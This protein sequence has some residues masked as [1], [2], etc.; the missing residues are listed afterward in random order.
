[1]AQGAI[2]AK[3]PS[4]STKSKKPAVLGPKKGSR[5]IAPKKAV[6]VKNAKITKVGYH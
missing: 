2:K 5:T 4:A 6:L 3:K 1:M